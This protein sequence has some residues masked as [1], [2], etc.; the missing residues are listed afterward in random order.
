MKGKRRREHVIKVRED[1]TTSDYCIVPDNATGIRDDYP[2]VW[3][4]KRLDAAYCTECSGPL[5]AMLS[6]CRHARKIKRMAVA[7]TLPT[8]ITATTEPADRPTVERRR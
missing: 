6:S 2:V 3:Y 4:D 5:A 7:R 1:D 8:D